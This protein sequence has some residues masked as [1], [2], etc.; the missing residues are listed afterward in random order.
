MRFGSV[1]YEKKGKIAILTLDEPDKLNA[2]SAGIRQGLVEGV[3]AAEDDTDIRVIIFT[4]G[5]GKAFCAGADISG[6]DFSPAATQ[7]FM[8]DVIAVLAIGET[9]TKPV[10][11]AVNGL[12][13]GGGFELAIGSD[14]IIASDK[15]KF[16]V[17]EINLGLLPGF[18]IVRLKE[19]IGRQKAKEMSMTGDAI[20]AEEALRLRLVTR[21]VPH[22]NLMEETMKLAEQIAS[23]PRIAVG[24]AKVAYNRGLGGE[25]MAYA[26]GAMPFLFSTHDTREGVTAFLEKRKPNFEE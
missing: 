8:S 20:S 4:G 1:E 18:A 14:I 17:P 11:S 16:G 24:L 12:A 25:E 3:K 13:L 7:K 15:A 23:K 19:I 21:V 22:E 6:F 2:L 26:K 10:I 5:T 9:C